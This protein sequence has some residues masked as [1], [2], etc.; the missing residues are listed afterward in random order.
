MEAAALYCYGSAFVFDLDSHPAETGDGGQAVGAFQEVLDFR[1]SAGDGA[2]HDAAVG[3][4]FIAGDCDLPA[5]MSCWF[6]FHKFLAFCRAIFPV[7][8]YAFPR[9]LGGVHARPS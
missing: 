7:Y 5:D 3:D 8:N 2:Q 1:F 6:Q 9:G 4:G